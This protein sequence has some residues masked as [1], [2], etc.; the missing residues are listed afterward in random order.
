MKYLSMLALL[1]FLAL[2]Y[3]PAAQAKH[4]SQAPAEDALS[5]PW[6]HFVREAVSPIAS[7]RLLATFHIG[8][9]INRYSVA[10]TNC[11]SEVKAV[12]LKVLGANVTVATFGIKFTDG[13]SRDFNVNKTFNAGTDSGWIDLG[14]FR[15]MDQR[16]PAGVYA[17]ASSN[18][19]ATVQV[20]GDVR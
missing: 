6:N 13:T 2:S 1:P 4:V 9:R 20:F 19:S 8:S 5:L 3:L 14:M 16:C 7:T 17:N 10:L 18:G 11:G 12:N 15:A